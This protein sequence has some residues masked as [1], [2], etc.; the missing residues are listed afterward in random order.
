MLAHQLPQ[1]PDVG[2]VIERIASGLLQ[3][4]DHAIA[5]V[6]TPLRPV[7]ASAGDTP[8]PAS[9]LRFWGEASGSAVEIIRFA[10]ANRIH[11]E[12]EYH[13]KHRVVEPY[14]LRRARA[15]NV[16]LYGWELASGQIKAFDLRKIFNLRVASSSFQPR[17]AIELGLR[18]SSIPP[19]A[20]STQASKPSGWRGPAY[21]YECTTCG[22][23]FV[24]KKHSGRLLKHNDERGYPCP[25]RGGYFVETV[26]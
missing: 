3:W 26:Y 25:G 8:L 7:V 13:A 21:V 11:V 20:R 17:Y 10:G 1:L 15:G 22:R 24:H 19:V 14:S 2:G 6:P 9:A 23:R 12:F 18:V 16:L 5:A 4:I